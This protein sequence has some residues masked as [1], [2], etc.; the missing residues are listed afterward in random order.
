M[1]LQCMHILDALDPSTHVLWYSVLAVVC[2]QP[3]EHCAAQ[4]ETYSNLFAEVLQLSQVIMKQ[5]VY[6]RER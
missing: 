1:W 2:N 3:C 6:I 5:Q 4:S